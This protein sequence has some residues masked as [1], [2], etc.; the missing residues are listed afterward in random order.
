M[1]VLFIT[2]GYIMAG[3]ITA[4]ICSLLDKELHDDMFMLGVTIAFWP[5]FFFATVVVGPFIGLAYLLRR[6]F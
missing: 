6:F 4:K 1:T 2:L 3:L 5:I